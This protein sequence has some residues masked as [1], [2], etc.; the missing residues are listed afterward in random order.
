MIGMIEQI[1]RDD[2]NDRLLKA[3]YSVTI[4]QIILADSMHAF[5]Y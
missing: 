4:K 5:A 2:S 3:S 1:I